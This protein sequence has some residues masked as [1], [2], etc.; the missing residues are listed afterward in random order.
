MDIQK[1]TSEMLYERKRRAQMKKA[2]ADN[3]ADKKRAQ[4]KDWD[5]SLS[6]CPNGGKRDAYGKCPPKKSSG[7]AEDIYG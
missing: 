4:M 2:E 6:P 7:I 5:E 1:K 3:D